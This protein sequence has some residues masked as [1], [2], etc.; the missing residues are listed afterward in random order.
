MLVYMAF[1]FCKNQPSSFCM[2]VNV[3]YFFV[4]HET[5]VHTVFEPL[6]KNTFPSFHAS[7]RK[8][9]PLCRFNTGY[10]VTV[11]VQ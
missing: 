2:Y 7:R 10:Y 3:M 4:M 6:A 8:R 1:V 9:F 11:A 5:F